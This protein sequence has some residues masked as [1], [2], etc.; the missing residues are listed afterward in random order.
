[1]MG[2]RSLILGA[3]LGAMLGLGA[4]GASANPYMR[5]AVPGSQVL[6]SGCVV[7]FDTPDGSPR[8]HANQAH[9]CAGVESVRIDPGSG[10]LQVFQT[11]SGVKDYAIL[12]AIAQADETLG[13]RGIVAG[14][15]GGTGDTHYYFSDLK[16]GRRLDLRNP[17]DRMRLQ[18]KY[19]NAWLGW[20]HVPW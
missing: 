18:G 16:L 17:S 7:R 6:I 1:M 11:V 20:V 13:D 3:A 8:I 19:S 5:G 15:S 2:R 14:A 4:K 10:A 12:F 9:L